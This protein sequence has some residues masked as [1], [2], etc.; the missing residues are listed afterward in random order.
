MVRMAITVKPLDDLAAALRRA[1]PELD[2]VRESSDAP[3]YLVGGAVRDLLLG[4]GR[5][6]T[7][8]SS[9]SATR[10]RW[11]RRL[12]AD[13]VEHERFAT[14]KVELDGHEVDIATAR[15]E[16]YAHPGALPEVAPAADDRDR[17]GSPRLHDQRDG[18]AAA[19][20]DAS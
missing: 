11:P 15:S 14:A 7:S 2:S 10:R 16:T 8:T 12:G 5:G 13:P 9:S 4:R 20:R 6:P 1:Y 18:A 3:V 17:P 19:G